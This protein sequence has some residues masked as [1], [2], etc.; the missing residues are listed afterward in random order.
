MLEVDNIHSYYGD[1]HVL[2]GVSLQVKP[3]EVTSILGRNGAGKTTTVLSI[4]GYLKPRHGTVVYDG[5]PINGLPSHRISRMG[6]GFVPQERGVFPSLSVE[7]NLTVAARPGRDGRWTLDRIYELFP[8]LKERRNNR[9]FQLS[10]G[11][12]QMVSIAR[13]LLLN[14]SVIIL[15]EPSEGLAPLI[16][17]EIVE[18]LR[19]MK[20]E[21]LAILLIEQN[22]KA[23]LDLGDMH[24]VLSKGEVC[25]TGTSDSLRGNDAVLST[26]LSV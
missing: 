13:A 8:R 11:E 6:L 24:Y 14:P 23:A 16:V 10:G 22:L 2:R 19:K 7:E 3:G 1:S 25:F 9:G 18:I 20:N 12:Q 15:D 26:H 5:K 4:M 21:G 17:D